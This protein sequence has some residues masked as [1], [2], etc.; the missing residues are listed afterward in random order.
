MSKPYRLQPV[1]DKKRQKWRLDLPPAVS[2]SGKRERHL[3]EKHYEALA[4]ANRIKQTFR[5]FGRSVRMLPA[6][7][8]IEAIE[9]W[10]K[11]DEVFAGEAAS[12][13]LRKIVLREVKAIQEREKSVT[14]AALIEDYIQ[15]LQRSH[16]SQNYLKQFANLK[17]HMGFWLESKVSEI[18][19][20][21]IKFS[22]GK[23]PS[24]QFNSDLR[25]LRAVFS[26]GLKNS[27]L[28]SN[29]TKQVEF[30]HRPKVEV[31]SLDHLTVERMFRHAQKHN[32]ELVA[33]Y[34][35]G[36]F[37]G[38]RESE[39]WKLRYSEI[40][41][42]E[43]N[44]IVPAAFSKTKKKRLVPLSDNAIEWLQWY[45]RRRGGI[46]EPETRL[47]HAFSPYKLRMSQLAN[48]KAAA[49]QGAQWQQNC[50]RHAF[51]SHFIAANRNMTD[52]GLAMGHS[53]TELTFEHYVGAVS[54][55]AGLAYF[56]IRP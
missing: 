12:G 15:K 27:W 45:F 46:C 42:A 3:F 10:Q 56:Q 4:E 22:L 19:P 40:R 30:V 32:L 7:R 41:I 13:S 52:L 1:L 39:L 33:P 25:L 51:A 29:P 21:N 34:T 53:T 55:E 8:L 14:L 6:N 35:I 9:A 26:H 38:L 31:K 50:K 5:D 18:T 49:G 44:V 16:R 11:L 20:G 47:L 28:K 36:F 2:P 17:R 48:F 24:G 23:F 37:C 43:K 54:H